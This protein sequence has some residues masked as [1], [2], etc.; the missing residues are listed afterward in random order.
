MSFEKYNM[1][2]LPIVHTKMDKQ[3]K[4]YNYVVCDYP[5][6][7]ENALDAGDEN[8]INE[9]LSDE[10]PFVNLIYLKKDRQIYV[11]Q[12]SDYDIKRMLSYRTDNNMVVIHKEER[13][14]LNDALNLIDKITSNMTES[15]YRESNLYKIET[16]NND[17]V[18]RYH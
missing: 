11:N 9:W 5:F 7:Y 12:F 3:P 16:H 8:E 14:S 2:K 17:I 6:L 13:I 18:F 10:Y 1:D 15:I 4:M